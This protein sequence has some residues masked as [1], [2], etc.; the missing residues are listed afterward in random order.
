MQWHLTNDVS[1]RDRNVRQNPLFLRISSPRCGFVSQ[2]CVILILMVGSAQATIVSVDTLTIHQGDDV[3]VNVTISPTEPVKGWE[4]KVLYDSR[5]LRLDTISEGDFFRGY[6]T[7]YR[8]NDSLAYGLIVGQG[9]VSAAGVLGI[10]HFTALIQ[11]STSVSL[12]DLGVCNETRYLPFSLINGT[13]TIM[14]VT[15]SRSWD[16]IKTGM[17]TFTNTVVLTHG[18][19]RFRN[20]TVVIPTMKND[21]NPW[22]GMIIVIVGAGL[23]L[24]VMFSMMNKL[25]RKRR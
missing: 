17:S 16:T 9:N 15:Q 14:G 5:F 6:L 25:T 10:L 7:F 3:L 23:F 1:Q 19:T 11:G 18:W 2:I 24:G 22:A 13:I 20:E 21:E 12:Y 4:F 8:S